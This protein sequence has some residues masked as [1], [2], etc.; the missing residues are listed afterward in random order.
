MRVRLAVVGA[1]LGAALAVSAQDE[2]QR[3][4]ARLNVNPAEYM[5][6]DPTAFARGQQVLLSGG[7]FVPRTPLTAVLEQDGGERPFPPLRA[8]ERGTL[9]ATVAIPAQATPGEDAR[10]RV[11]GAGDHGGPR[12]L[13]SLHLKI[14]ADMGDRDGDG[15]KDMC[16]TCP[17]LASENQADDDA[18][19]RGDACDKCPHDSSD[20][21]DGDGLCADVDPNPYAPETK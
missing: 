18:D 14:F 21:E 11:E 5:E 12:L 10:I 9:S 4:R 2:P 20:D 7:G 15:V 16:D 1:W 17:D 6:C 13:T 3:L 19:G 8:T